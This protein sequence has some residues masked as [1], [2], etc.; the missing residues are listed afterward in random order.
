[1]A[2]TLCSRALL[3]WLAG[4]GLAAFETGC[5]VAFS[6]DNMLTKAPVK[7]SAAFLLD[8]PIHK[9]L[10]GGIVKDMSRIR[11]RVLL[12]HESV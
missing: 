1:M 6:P 7:G 12:K 5:Q 2:H 3:V 11:K 4:A 10:R 9:S 8:C